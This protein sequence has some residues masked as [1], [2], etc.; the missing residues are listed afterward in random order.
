MKIHVPN[1]YM[2]GGSIDRGIPSQDLPVYD[3]GGSVRIQS[4]GSNQGTLNWIQSSFLPI[5]KNVHRVWNVEMAFE[6]QIE[7]PSE[8]V[9]ITIAQPFPI[10]LNTSVPLIGYFTTGIQP[11]ALNAFKY[12]TASNDASGN[13]VLTFSPN[14]TIV[15]INLEL[16]YVNLSLATMI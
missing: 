12:W 11:I 9:T 1:Y 5:S 13:V 14:S 10:P 3:D 4:S 6:L 15:G 8:V 7:D 2:A 16:I